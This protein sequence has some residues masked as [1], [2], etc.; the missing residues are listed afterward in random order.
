MRSIMNPEE[1]RRRIRNDYNN[2]QWSE[3]LANVEF[4]SAWDSGNLIRACEI[5][6]RVVYPEAGN[7]KERRE[8]RQLIKV[9]E[10][11]T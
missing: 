7:K 11:F 5:A 10:E 2:N 8:A 6:P 4:K 1:E 9:L 3:L